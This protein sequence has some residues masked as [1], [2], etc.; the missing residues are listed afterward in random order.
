MGKIVCVCVCV[1]CITN[2]LW[3]LIYLTVPNIAYLKLSSA[4]LKL[5]HS[6]SQMLCLF[7]SMGEFFAVTVIKKKYTIIFN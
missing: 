5:C 3:V 4:A 1:C 2:G 7:D 6:A